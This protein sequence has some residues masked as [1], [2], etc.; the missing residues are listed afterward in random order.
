[1]LQRKTGRVARER[2]ASK[3]RKSRQSQCKKPNTKVT[4]IQKLRRKPL[5]QYFVELDANS[6]D[7]EL[8]PPPT[9]KP[10]K[11]CPCQCQG[12]H[13]QYQQKWLQHQRDCTK[14]SLAISPRRVSPGLKRGCWLW[15]WWW[16]QH[17]G[18]RVPIYTLL[19]L[20]RMTRNQMSRKTLSS[21]TTAR[22]AFLW[23]CS[24]DPW[25]P[26]C[27][28]PAIAANIR[29]R[30]LEERVGCMEDCI[31]HCH[32]DCGRASH[33]ILLLGGRLE[34]EEC[35]AQL[36][37][38]PGPLVLASASIPLLSL[39]LEAVV[40]PLV[41]FIALTPLSSQE[42][43]Q[44]ALA[45]LVPSPPTTQDG[46]SAMNL[47]ADANTLTLAIHI[48]NAN[49]NAMQ[50]TGNE[51]ANAAIE[52]TAK[53]KTV[54]STGVL[55]ANTNIVEAAGNIDVDANTII[56][57]TNAGTNAMEASGD[58]H[59]NANTMDASD[60]RNANANAQLSPAKY[61]TNTN[62]TATA[63]P[64]LSPCHP[65]AAALTTLLAIPTSPQHSHL[66][67]GL[68]QTVAPI[69]LTKTCN[70]NADI[71]IKTAA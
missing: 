23:V 25:V 58:I 42:H 38:A 20:S 33:F 12:Q 21:P 52:S 53:A 3:Q 31:N 15:H 10:T 56:A 54:W 14:T 60:E 35:L 9:P 22:S 49:A 13:A 43:V 57:V 39:T 71:V 67:Q 45:A 51:N 34:I 28:F 48:A 59:A 5:T 46:P 27:L 4:N 16:R 32:G 47:D 19:L 29:T 6:S 61:N 18:K 1:M 65:S 63:I 40:I 36:I 37:Y 11:M 17:H 70:A 66:L 68:G 50:A 24:I 64:S 30:M 26:C 7:E 69:G 55:N 41:N 44:C 62:I 8:S 2:E